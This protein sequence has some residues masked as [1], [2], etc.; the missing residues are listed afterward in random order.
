MIFWLYKKSV[1]ILVCLSWDKEIKQYVFFQ[2]TKLASATV[3][4]TKEI[5]ATVNERVNI[6]FYFFKVS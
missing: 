1:Q 3:Q 4:R 5:G 6:Y 2:A